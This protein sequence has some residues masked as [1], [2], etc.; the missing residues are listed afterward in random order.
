MEMERETETE[1]SRRSRLNQI[2]K[3]VKL[4]Q[5]LSTAAL[6]AALISW[7]ATAN[8]L[9]QFAFSKLWQAY[10]ISGALQGALFALSIMGIGILFSL[11][12]IK[13]LFFILIW[14]SLLISSSIFSYV[15]ISKI[16]YSERLLQED[17]HRIFSTYCLTENYALSAEASKLLEGTE[18]NDGVIRDMNEYVNQLAVL[19]NGI[20]LAEDGSDEKIKI[21]RTT[22]LSY[23]YSY[24]Q[25]HDK[26][27]EEIQ[28]CKDTSKLVV[29]LDNILTGR[30]TKRDI[31]SVKSQAEDLGNVIKNM[32]E[33]KEK[34]RIDRAEKVSDLENRLETFTSLSSPEYKKAV[35][36]RDGYLDEFNNLESLIDNLTKEAEQ[37]EEVP[38]LLESIEGNMASTLYNQ[39][40]EIRSLMNAEK[41]D[42]EKIQGVAEEIYNTLIENSVNITPGDSRLTN[43]SAFKRNLGKYDAIIMAQTSIDNEIQALYNL[44]NINEFD[45]QV[46]WRK[47]WQNHLNLLKENAKRLRDGGLDEQLITDF[48]EESE[49][50][51]R[52]YLSDL[53]DFERAW[54]L[55]F[56][57]SPRHPYKTLLVFSCIL[58]FGID[59][60]SVVISS[61]LYLFKNISV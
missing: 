51:E 1:K 38:N 40:F 12:A 57:E 54:G 28:D 10:V 13:R 29:G 26:S 59:L 5:M 16:V 8:G 56:S 18:N 61:L 30:F 11:N 31:I 39:V 45:D 42:T 50:M 25:V 27:V 23:A 2:N 20:N 6:S 60:F 17:A 4:R 35:E 19:E 3:V 36:E 32:R 14:A 46:S 37:I 15:F 9:Y 44:K 47:Y 21:I 43:Y 7:L 41:I 33:E 58:A 24:N 55:L 48:V 49:S 22:L 53:T 52:R 34:I